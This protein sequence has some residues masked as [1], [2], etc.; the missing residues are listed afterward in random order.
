MRA[1]TGM[2][3]SED[4]SYMGHG[5]KDVQS[6]TEWNIIVEF[7]QRRSMSAIRLMAF[8]T[9]SVYKEEKTNS[10]KK[11]KEKERKRETKDKGS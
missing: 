5:L 11:K 8:I 10:N 3:H 1:W 2:I 7:L 6:L 4:N 9:L